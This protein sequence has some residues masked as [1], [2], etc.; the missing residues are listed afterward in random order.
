M[1]ATVRQAI[2]DVGNILQEDAF[3]RR[4]VVGWLVGEGLDIKAWRGN[5]QQGMLTGLCITS[6]AKALLGKALARV[7]EAGLTM[8]SI[9]SKRERIAAGKVVAAPAQVQRLTKAQQ[10]RKA[11]AGSHSLLKYGFTIRD[12]TGKEK[13]PP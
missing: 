8:H 9:A 1:V 13:Y 10:G 3:L 12:P 5:W 2:S 4:R 7:V 11:G 6:K